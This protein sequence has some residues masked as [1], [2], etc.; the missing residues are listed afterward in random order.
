MSLI[1]HRRNIAVALG[2]GSGQFE[3]AYQVAVAEGAQDLVV[4]DLDRD[5]ILDIAASDD[6]DGSIPILK[7]L[8]NGA[9]PLGLAAA[10]LDGNT[11]PDLAVIGPDGLDVLLNHTYLPG[12]PF[13]DFGHG[14]EGSF[15]YPVFLADGTLNGGD[16]VSFRM[17][18]AAPGGF[19]WFVIGLTAIDLPFAAGGVVVPAP[20]LVFDPFVPPTTGF[21]A[22]TG[23]RAVTS[24]D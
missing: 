4:A 20:D 22:T 11:Y 8:G 3:S 18:H 16:P 14:L 5:D 23:V 12:S 17:S 21:A 10:D 19:G 6:L 24:G 13:L 7:G 2:D 1:T 9:T 15:G